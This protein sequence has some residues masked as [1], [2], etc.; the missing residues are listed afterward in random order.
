VINVESITGLEV[1]GKDVTLQPW[2]VVVVRKNPAYKTQVNVRIEGEVAY[3]GNYV[4]QS[5]NERISNLL[6]RAGGL[7]REAYPLGVYVKKDQYKNHSR[8]AD[9][10]EN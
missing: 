8:P 7:T 9:E 2:D 5:K 1:S 10:P 6:K 3:P 4:I